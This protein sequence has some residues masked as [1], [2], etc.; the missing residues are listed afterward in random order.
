MMGIRTAGAFASTGGAMTDFFDVSIEG[1][2]SDDL[3][4][5]GSISH[6]VTGG[7]THGT[8]SSLVSEW[9]A[10]R[11]ESFVIGAELRRVLQE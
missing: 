8:K 7:G 3:S 2:V 4:L 10:A 9:S 1:R 6:G 11:A 5:F